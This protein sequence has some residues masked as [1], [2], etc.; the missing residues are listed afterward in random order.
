MGVPLLGET[1]I[2]PME[3][4]PPAI[5]TALA[6][7]YAKAGAGAVTSSVGLLFWGA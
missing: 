3:E 4:Q 1:T 5:A 7:A 2:F 6:A